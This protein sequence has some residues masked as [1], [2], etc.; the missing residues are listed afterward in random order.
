MAIQVIIAQAGPLPIK[1]TFPAIGSEPMYLEV[2]G[3]VW[4]NQRNFMIGIAI[5][6]D[7]KPI[8]AAQ[9]YSNL[10][11]THRAVAPAYIP[12]K[13]TA[14]QHTL[15]LSTNTSQTVSDS[16]DFYNAVIHY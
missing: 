4:G 10:D 3:T 5:S 6:L 12:I 14:G 9:I 15:V 11:T 16:N 7:G 13:L 2:T 8:G 1:A